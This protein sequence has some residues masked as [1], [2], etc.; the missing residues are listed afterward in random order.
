MSA[1]SAL[2]LAAQDGPWA[3]IRTGTVVEASGSS[4]VVLV[5]AS[6][7]T[8]S[9]VVP[10]GNATPEAPAVGTLVAVGRQD[11]SW[12]VF[13]SILG[14]SGN[15]IL[16]GSFEDSPAGAAPS[17]WTLANVTNTASA[18]VEEVASPVAGANVLVV[19]PVTNPSTSIVYSSPVAVETGE[20]FQLSAF[21]G[22]SYDP[23]VAQT[24]DASLLALWF[25]NATDTYPT[26]SS[27]DT[28]VASATDVLES[29]PWTPLSGSV[30]APVTGFMRVGLRSVVDSAQS[31]QWD[32]VTARQ[33]G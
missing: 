17:D 21:A 31:M 30:T 19:A 29:P 26:T 20:V 3:Q 25:A 33:F 27:P 12:I 11:S 2:I 15:L 14:A 4:A 8:A 18:T 23:V 24:A 16:N 28:T 1:S 9:V 32:F 22:G 13:G 10:F 5:G 7:F 6:T